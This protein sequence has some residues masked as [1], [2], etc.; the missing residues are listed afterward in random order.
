VQ[1]PTGVQ[2]IAR[3]GRVD[4]LN[5]APP[6]AWVRAVL[7]ATAATLDPALPVTPVSVWVRDTLARTGRVRPGAGPTWEV[8][9][10]GA[11]MVDR[12]PDRSRADICVRAGNRDERYEVSLEF[13]SGPFQDDLG[14][15]R[16]PD[17]PAFRTGFVAT[18][19]ESM[20][21][22]RLSDLDTALTKPPDDWPAP[23]L[24]VSQDDIIFRPPAPFPGDVV[25]VTFVVHNDGPSD[26][27]ALIDYALAAP[28]MTA[29]ERGQFHADVPAGGV[30][31]FT[32]SV[33][34]PLVL[35]AGHA[36]IQAQIARPRGS[37]RP[38]RERRMENNA[39]AKILGAWRRR[40]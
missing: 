8:A 5:S 4:A 36:V 14:P 18:L 9:Y 12:F 13:S 27:R 37:M 16:A 34:L 32:R 22:K 33:R 20:E 15:R 35:G 38:V 7:D 30:Y 24:R 2:R 11:D 40:F 23:D 31:Q 1:S 25:D 21:L 29:D 3:P 17:P 19:S 26:E 39:A 6:E 28:G 10:C